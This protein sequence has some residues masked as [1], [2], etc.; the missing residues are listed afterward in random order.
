MFTLEELEKISNYSHEIICILDLKGRVKK[1]NASVRFV[2]GYNPEELIG[3]NILDL[4]HPEDR[5]KT[6]A[7]LERITSTGKGTRFFENRYL[8]K[9]GSYRWLSWNSVPGENK[10]IYSLGRDITKKKE[11]IEALKVS[12]KRYRRV[13]EMSPNATIIFK[14]KE[15]LYANRAAKQLFGIEEAEELV[16]DKVLSHFHPDKSLDFFNRLEDLKGERDVLTLDEEIVVRGDGSQVFVE[17]T[18]MLFSN[19]GDKSWQCIITDLTE[20]KRLEEEYF[21]ASKLESLGVLAGGIAHDFNNLLT[22]IK[23]NASLAKI[24][25]N[26]HKASINIA[27]IE[28][29]AIQSQELTQHLLTFSKG[30]A[31]I[32]EVYNIGELLKEAITLMLC[33]SNVKVVSNINEK[34]Y[35]EV[36]KGQFN[37]VVNNIII[38]AIHAM[39]EGGVIRIEATKTNLPEYIHEDPRWEYNRISVIDEGCGISEDKLQ[40]VFDPYYT[41]KENGNGLGLA[42]TYSIIRKHNGYINVSS[43]LGQGTIVDIYLPA[44]KQNKNAVLTQQD[45]SLHKGKGKVLVMDDEEAIRDMATDMLQ[46]LG[47]KAVTVSKGEEAIS[48]YLRA[49]EMNMPYDLVLLDLTVPGGMGGKDTIE[50]L[51]V[52]NP[53]VK[54]IVASGYTNDLV[55]FNYEDYGFKY[56]IKKPYDIRRLGQVLNRSRG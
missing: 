35:S 5:E 53:S 26:N 31:P 9:G 38:N 56:F 1:I 45:L 2:L 27:E 33:G 3:K 16:F 37:Q 34:L 44:V 28:K 10:A 15:I 23:G 12:E 39:A 30:G 21:Q 41:T 29:A 7:E 13:V 43:Q 48:E 20:R 40:K 49:M 18:I 22:V 42:V 51:K 47:Y 11:V 52:I 54:A 36:D 17:A 6:M 4:I 46:Q 24:K 19:R 32:K 8:H 50:K 25:L 55:M 14:R